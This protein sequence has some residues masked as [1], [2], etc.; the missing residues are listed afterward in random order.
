[1]SIGLARYLEK[2]SVLCMPNH[3]SCMFELVNCI[4]FCEVGK[5][6]LMCV[7]EPCIKAHDMN[8]I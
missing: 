6:S 3:Y 1:M 8:V 5:G 7:I 2:C 4:N